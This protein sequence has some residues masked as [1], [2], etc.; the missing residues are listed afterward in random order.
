MRGIARKGFG[1]AALVAAASVLAAC[2]GTSTTPSTSAL[3]GVYGKIP[4]AASGPQHTG[5]I[6]VSEP[7]SSTPTAIIPLQ[8]T[9]NYSVF[10]LTLFDYEMWRPLYWTVV[11]TAPQYNPTYSLADYPVV[12]NG[13][14]TFTITM[15]S[16]KWSDGQ[17]VTSKDVAFWYYLLK[18]AVKES[19]ANW[20]G[21]TPNVGLPDQVASVT[22][23]NASTIVFT[24]K[25]AVNPS[26]LAL[27]QLGSVQPMPSH[28]WARASAGGPLLDFTVAANATKIYNYLISQNKTEATWASNPLWKTVDGPY[29]LQSFNSTNAAYTMVP[30]TH[31]SGPHATKMSDYSGVPFTSDN[32]EYNGVKASN[33]QIGYV[34]TADLPQIGSIKALGYNVYGYPDFGWLY[35][36]YNF[37]DTTGDFNNIIKQLY[38]RQ[39]LA[40]L[41]DQAGVIHAFFGGA[42]APAFGPVPTLPKSPY[43][44]PNALINPYPYSVP[45]AI[46]LLK[47][48]GWNVVPGGTTTC[49]H[50]GTAAGECGAGIPAGTKLAWNLIYTTTPANIAQQVTAYASEAK[51]AGI[52]LTLKS[53]NFN[54]IIANYDD[55]AAPKND[56]AWAMEDFGGFT[57]STYPTTLGVFNCTGSVNEGGYCDPTA[58]SLIHASVFGTNPNAVKSEAEYLT[59]QAPALFQPNVSTALES[60]NVL[61][62]KTTLSGPPTAFSSITQYWI[63]PELM[64][65]TK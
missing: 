13:G 49:A 24:M 62:W 21:Y 52:E 57:D 2:G 5:N 12:S 38:I 26:W 16:Y 36:D 20:G 63:N 3:F 51:K 53:S 64:Y 50:A 59:T 35:M 56:N 47:A 28:A 17:P 14:K 27:D 6:T 46:A 19:P 23:P 40:H 10:T 48:H 42:A 34:P 43:A 30:N 11:G 8:P 37:K 60:G 18:A 65:F 1:L 58:D 31:Y 29:V 33:V 25:S 61:V 55:P 9:A 7:P 4:A 39:A 32:A 45:D 54:Y 41:Q 22:T 44:P 15:K